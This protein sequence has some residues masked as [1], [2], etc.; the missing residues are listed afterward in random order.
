MKVRKGFYGVRKHAA[1]RNPFT[2]D[3]VFEIILA[4]VHFWVVNVLYIKA[5]K[6]W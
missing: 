2:S 4:K 5:G 6:E 1:S 3:M